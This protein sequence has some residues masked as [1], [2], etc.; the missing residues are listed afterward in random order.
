MV[1]TA[2]YLEDFLQTN[3]FVHAGN[4]KLCE[5]EK[6]V[7]SPL[8]KKSNGHCEYIWYAK[9]QDQ[10]VPLYIGKAKNG[11]NIRMNKHIGGFREGNS[12]SNS[13]RRIK[14]ILIE[15]FKVNW[16]IEVYT[17][18]SLNSIV[19]SQLTEGFFDF[20]LRNSDDFIYPNIPL[21]SLEEELLIRFFEEN[22][23]HLKLINGIKEKYVADL[24]SKLIIL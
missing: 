24:I 17:R 16:T 11:V 8:L 9:K 21:Y 18:D 12:G 4:W 2:N 13:G 22:F 7:F 6:I 14:R 15:L 1:D 3:Q 23:P 19:I 5:D 20:N 10:I